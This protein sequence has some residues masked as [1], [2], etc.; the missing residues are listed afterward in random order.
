MPSINRRMELL[1]QRLPHVHYPRAARAQQPFVSI[2]R[3][4]VHVLEIHW[5]CANRLN[6]VQAKQNI[7]PMQQ[8]SD[9]LE[10][11]SI[12]THEMTRGEGDEA[13]ILVDLAD[14]VLGPN[15]AQ[16]TCVQ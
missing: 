4:E 1:L 2:C 12:T 15:Q 13:R 11:D 14:H 8:A 6:G 3:Q 7:P 16:V 10:I 5:K 9:R